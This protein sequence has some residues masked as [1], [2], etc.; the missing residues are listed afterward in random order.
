MGRRR[1]S[2]SEEDAAAPSAQDPAQSKLPWGME[3]TEMQPS[4]LTSLTDDKLARFVLGHQKK[5]K[6]QKE[7]ED[8]EAKKRQ[9]DEEAAR[10]YAT[11]VASFDNEDD[12]K[13]KAF[14][15]GGTQA[16]QG[17]SQSAVQS[18]DVYRLKGKEQVASSSS[19][20]KVSEMDKLLQEIKQKDA[21]QRQMLQ[22]IHRPK[23][24]RAIDEFL[25]EMKER[26]P[27]PVS[28]EGV[29]MTKGSFDNGDPETTNLYVG[30]LAPTVT[31]E[32]LQAEFGRYGEVYSVKIMWPRSEEE[33]ARK[34][35]CGF[36]SFY[37]R[38]DADDAR[39]NLDNKQLEGQPMIVGW[40]KAVKIQPQA[41]APG[42][43]LPSVVPNPLVIATPAA[44]TANIDITG[45]QAVTIE[46]P[47]DQEVRRRVN[48]LAHYVAADGLQFEN[49]VRMREA[50]NKAYSFLFDPQS[51]LALY[52]R[53]RVYSFAMGDDE[54]SW[55]EK[56]FQMTLEG[57]VWI[58]PKMPSRSPR[59]RRRGSHSRS[60]GRYSH[61][62][63]GA[64]HRS[65]S[66]GRSYSRSRS[67][68][69]SR[70][71]R[72]SRRRSRSGSR[73][74]SRSSSSSSGDDRSSR[75]SRRRTRKRRSRSRSRGRR[76]RSLSSDD[77]SSR[78]RSRHSRSRPR[79]DG[80][81]HDENRHESSR[82]SRRP[83]GRG[84]FS[85]GYGE[86]N[87]K[88][89]TGQQIARAR[90]MERGRE[91][92]RLSNEDYDTF[93]ELLD[94]LT[95]ERESVKKT[96]GF[97]LDNSE[98]AVDLVNII[99]ES[100]KSSTSSGV[101]LVGLLYV[102]SDIL[103]NSSAAVKNASLFRTT[104]Q[105][106]LPEIMD[107]LRIAHKSIAGR[108]SANAMKEKVM[109]VL[110]AWESW[111]LFPPAVLVGL[112]ATF[113][114]KVEEDEYIATHSLNFDGIGESDQ[115]RL[116][117][118]CRQSGIMATGDAKR[119]AVRL[120]WLKEFTS[121]TAL[122]APGSTVNPSFQSNTTSNVRE[123]A[124]PT[125]PDIDTND[126]TAETI[127]EDGK[128]NGNVDD[129]DGEPIDGE[130][131]VEDS[132][133][134]DGEL[135]DDG[136]LDGEPLDGD[137]AEDDLDGEPLDGEDLDGAPMDEED[138]DGEPI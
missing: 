82:E 91:R 78:K 135:M 79:K 53:W 62:D 87:E 98:A 25:E 21:E 44:S 125:A 11:F 57:P 13:G 64:S 43:I 117:K 10:I 73:H 7:R 80:R 37:K 68:S 102:T 93:K 42:L 22:T 35:N 5:T 26:G 16:A 128:G 112:H 32:V 29:G 105:E 51:A 134:I 83:G 133:D 56:P 107:T 58:P 95:L 36:V 115:E 70:S 46:I 130:P 63:R 92:N 45:K 137:T 2:H 84:G 85:Q 52:Y 9:A 122:I 94:E 39:I 90:D 99:L 48:H 104:F 113:L 31:E 47:I 41:H 12:T 118:T 28:M 100:F 69:S 74:R 18:R 101:A 124:T 4:S 60:S 76:S 138:L 15:R 40:G 116:R 66:R 24:R 1:P 59:D 110:T 6:F 126:E 23:K 19:G 50:N 86:K 55:R 123:T 72:R 38:R 97:A 17:H 30:N 108:M 129:L 131:I 65:H 8:R 114:R 88:L 67:R 127:S 103:H 27:A 54:H 75:R 61:H 106:C 109:N 20:K 89:L 14:V 121:P 120:Q 3:K 132:D 81:Q 77:S 111:S 34:R 49:A 96:M 119:L 136:V 33:R 71:P